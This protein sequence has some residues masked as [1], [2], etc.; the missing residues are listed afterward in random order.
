MPA[1]FLLPSP[2]VFTS[3]SGL[4]VWLFERHQVPLVAC[5]VVVPTG[6][7]SDPRGKAGLAHATAKMLVE[8]AGTRGPIE[9]AR[10]LDGLGARLATEADADASFVSFAVLK[11][12]AREAFGLFGDVVTRPRFDPAELQRMKDLWVDELLERDKDPDATARVVSRAVL[13]GPEHPYG[14]PA[15]GWPK[16]ARSVTIGDVRGFYAKAWRP[17]RATLVCAGDVTRDELTPMI[18]A[19]LGTWKAPATPAPPPLA[20][21]APRG[22]WPKLALVDRPDAPQA[23]VAVVRSG[24]PASSPDVPALGRVN[25]AIGGSFSSRLNQDLREK[26]GFTYGARTRF[27]VS[28]GPGLVVASANVATDKT[29]EALA[30]M[31]ADL[32]RFA[33]GGLTDDEVE[34]TRSQARAALVSA[35]ESVESVSGILAAD[36]S[37]G[38]G[39]D[40]EATASRARDEASRTLLDALARRYFSPDDAVLVIVGPRA[41]VQPQLDKA[42][43]PA[44]ELRDAHGNASNAIR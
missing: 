43:L 14:H 19:A 36:A 21:P 12:H 30:A 22:P 10:A 1:P 8:G 4:T 17:D 6:S 41:R 18:D 2:V 24:P 31:V 15:D 7:A 37:L 16:S 35:Y 32:R 34:R 9:L 40:Y 29:G 44:P 33:T 23:V 27:S 11:R 26:Q 42:G 13:F 5:D 38:L 25:D 28:R 39:P 3:A 20:P